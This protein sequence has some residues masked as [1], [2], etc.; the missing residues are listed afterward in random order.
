MPRRATEKPKKGSPQ[1]EGSQETTEREKAPSGAS[2]KATGGFRPKPIE[3]S[4]ANA[5]ELFEGGA[6]NREQF[7]RAMARHGWTVL[8]S[9]QEMARLNVLREARSLKPEKLD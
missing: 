5:K 6:I 1:P 9:N 7:V 8:Q 3:L 4:E 2:P